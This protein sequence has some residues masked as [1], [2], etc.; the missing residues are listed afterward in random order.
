MDQYLMEKKM[1]A[2]SP[3]SDSQIE[4]IEP[5]EHHSEDL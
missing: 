4:T 2:K 1:I 5:S 3:C